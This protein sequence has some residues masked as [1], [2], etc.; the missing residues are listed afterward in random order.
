VGELDHGMYATPAPV[1][2]TRLNGGKA[3][4]A[5]SVPEMIRRMRLEAAGKAQLQTA[6]MAM[7]AELQA[8]G[9]DVM[10]AQRKGAVTE[11]E[12]EEEL[13]AVKG[14]LQALRLHTLGAQQV[15]A[16]LE[17]LKQSAERNVQEVRARAFVLLP[18]PKRK[19]PVE[20]RSLDRREKYNRIRIRVSVF[21]FGCR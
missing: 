19:M 14:I 6:L 21:R 11:G 13:A 12:E 10:V 9:I 8:Q 3:A 5:L 7:R 20:R 16:E 17:T 4:G 18:D 2:P 1:S 15:K